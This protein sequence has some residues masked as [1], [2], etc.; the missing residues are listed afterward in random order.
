MCNLTT[1]CTRKMSL[2]NILR[3]PLALKWQWVLQ[4]KNLTPQNPSKAYTGA[5]LH[6]ENSTDPVFPGSV[7]SQRFR[8]L[9]NTISSADPIWQLRGLM[10]KRLWKQMKTPSHAVYA[11]LAI[12]QVFIVF[13]K[14]LEQI[15]LLLIKNWFWSR[16]HRNCNQNPLY[17]GQFRTSRTLKAAAV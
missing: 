14:S 3:S 17:S 16:E 11:Q 4:V 15:T 10:H 13:S 12:F 9:I 6:A 8:K 1:R 2:E 5:Q 7:S